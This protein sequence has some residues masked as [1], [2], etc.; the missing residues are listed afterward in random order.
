MNNFIII[1]CP[2]CRSRLRCKQRLDLEHK[3]ITC[4]VCKQKT[5]FCNFKIEKPIMPSPPIYL[6]DVIGKV[7]VLP[8]GP[9]YQLMKGWNVI[10]RLAMCLL[11]DFNIP[12]DNKRISRRHLIIDVKEGPNGGFLHY[13]SLYNQFVLEAYVGDHELKYDDRIVLRNGNIIKLANLELLFE[14]P[15]QAITPD[16]PMPNRYG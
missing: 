14:I 11:A 1:T 12:T 16:S 6:Y 10:G 15:G 3:T 5:A 7:T 13:V 9:S 2:S 4:P 8:D